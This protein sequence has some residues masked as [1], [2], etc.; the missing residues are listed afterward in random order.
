MQERRAVVLPSSAAKRTTK[1]KYPPV[2]IP[3]TIPEGFSMKGGLRAILVKVAF[4]ITKKQED[5]VIWWSRKGAYGRNFIRKLGPRVF[6]LPANAFSLYMIARLEKS[7]G[8]EFVNA[9]PAGFSSDIPRVPKD[10]ELLFQKMKLRVD[11][12]EGLKALSL[13]VY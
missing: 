6:E 4:G 3:P 11:E 8:S 9:Y 7:L 5:Y 10:V 2:K 12:V 13:R 1:A